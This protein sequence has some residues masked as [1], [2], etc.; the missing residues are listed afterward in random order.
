[1]AMSADP[2]M[3]GALR[4]DR[5]GG[6]GVGEPLVGFMAG[7]VTGSKC[8]EYPVGTLLGLRAPLCTVQVLSA[9]DLA[10]QPVWKLDGLLAEEAISR[11]VGALGM[12]GATAYGGLVDVLAPKE[13][14]VLLVTAAS[15]AVGALVGQIA[16]HKFGCRVIGTTGGAEK[17]ALL[18]DH[19]GFDA[20]ID[21]TAVGSDRAALAAAIAEAA[22]E[23]GK[24]DMVFESVG[25]AFFEAAFDCLGKGGRIAVCG[26]IS[27]Y[28]GAAAEPTPVKVDPLK[29]IYAAQRVEG[30]VCTPWLVGARGEFL[31]D[32]HAWL[33]EGWLK[34]DETVFD[35]V[36]AYG[37]AFA[38]LFN[39]KHTGK[40]VIKIPV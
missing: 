38:S 21:Y 7:K 37:E 33:Q 29:M 31:K 6:K 1:M 24:V 8:A 16:K 35:G 10:A 39:G 25:G 15:G 18:V 11:G 36:E 19:F 22:G 32:M 30:F 20:A 26:G 5:P 9:A 34:A 17:A 14:E 2:Y 3:R 13:G 4:T 12:P 23:G 40:V 28:G 27:L